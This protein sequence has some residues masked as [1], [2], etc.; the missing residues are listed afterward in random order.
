MRKTLREIIK[1]E[2]NN[3]TVN[4]ILRDNFGL[5]KKEISRLKFIEDG[6]LLNYVK[7]HVNKKVH[8]HDY[9]EVRFGKDN[10]LRRNKNIQLDVLYDDEDLIIVNKPVGIVCHKTHGY[11]DNDLGTMICDKYGLDKVRV[12]GRLD[13]DV[14]G[15]IVYAKSQPSAAR[16]SKERI[17]N[18][19]HKQYLAVI[20][21]RLIK[22]ADTLKYG[23]KK[24]DKSIKKEVDFNSDECETSYRVILENNKYSLLFVEIKTGKSH[25]IRAGFSALGYPLVGDKLYGGNTDKIKRPALHCAT[26]QLY[27]PFTDEMIKRYISLPEDM[28][29]LIEE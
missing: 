22:K 24:I 21:G 23:I 18:K 1:K 3:K 7:V 9:L 19:F 4:Q 10:Q 28:L 15:L 29:K 20:E 12:I 26:L 25:Q 11:L 17:E 14:S 5:S 6:I 13:K 16:L 27:Q 2:D 8:T